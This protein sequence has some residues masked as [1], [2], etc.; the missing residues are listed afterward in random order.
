MQRKR[1]RRLRQHAA[2]AARPAPAL[3][4]ADLVPRDSREWVGPEVRHAA[5]RLSAHRVGTI[6]L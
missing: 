3:P 4:P 2:V 1:R 5:L 6:E